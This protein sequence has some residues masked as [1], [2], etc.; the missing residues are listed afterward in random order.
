V[1][2]CLVDISDDEL[3]GWLTGP[4]SDKEKPLEKFL[5]LTTSDGYSAKLKQRAAET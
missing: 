4:E 2:C 5:A 3:R 1:E